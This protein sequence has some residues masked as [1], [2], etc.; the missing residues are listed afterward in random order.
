MVNIEV[1][2]LVLIHEDHPK[3]RQNWPLGIVIKLHFGI[4]GI[5]RAADVRTAKSVYTRDI[6]KLYN[7][8]LNA[9]CPELLEVQRSNPVNTAVDPSDNPNIDSVTDTV[10]SHDDTAS[11]GDESEDEVIPHIPVVTRASRVVKRR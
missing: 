1:G 6:R 8:E 2:R 10:V 3:R 7:L 9:S 5:C 11:Q 4:D